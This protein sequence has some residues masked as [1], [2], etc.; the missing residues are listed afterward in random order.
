MKITTNNN[1]VNLL[2]KAKQSKAK[3]SKA[4]QSHNLL[5][6]HY[7]IKYFKNLFLYLVKSFLISLFNYFNVVKII[8]FNCEVNND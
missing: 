7:Y 5:I 2:S 4:K 1:T 8:I 3:Q 6:I